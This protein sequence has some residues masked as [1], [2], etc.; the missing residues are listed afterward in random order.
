VT[1]SNTPP[2]PLNV[3]N[4]C[5]NHIV[6]ICV[7]WENPATITYAS[8]IVTYTTLATSA[9]SVTPV[10][11]G[12]SI[13]INGLTPA[14]SY[15]FVIVGLAANGQQSLATTAVTFTT[16]PADPKLDPTLD[17][18]NIVCDSVLD[19]TENRYDVDCTWSAAAQ[20]LTRLIVKWRCVSPI[21][22]NDRNKV[23]LYGTAAQ[24]TSYSFHVHRDVATCTLYFHAYYI[25][26]PASRHQLTVVMGS[27]GL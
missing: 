25:R 4:R 10:L 13:R 2:A 20:L 7:G 5:P 17:I 1:N 11:T 21:R 6:N 15:S 3:T 9:V 16:D 22:E 23:R 19:A 8:F 18:N 24:A 14:T 12:S 26:R 27:S